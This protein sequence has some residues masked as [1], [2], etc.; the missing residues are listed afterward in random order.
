VGAGWLH[1]LRGGRHTKDRA[2]PPPATRCRLMT[3]MCPTHCLTAR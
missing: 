3:P 2:Q 1:E